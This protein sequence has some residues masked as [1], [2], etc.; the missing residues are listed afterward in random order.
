MFNQTRQYEAS[1]LVKGKSITEYSH[2]DGNVYVEGRPGSEYEL[3]FKN[4]TSLRV[5]VIPSVDGLSVLDGKVAGLNSPGYVINGYGSISIPGWTLDKNQVAK[6][7]FQDTEKSYNA[8]MNKTTVNNGV[9]GFMVFQ[10][11]IPTFV[12]KTIWNGYDLN[13]NYNPF[14]P[15]PPIDWTYRSPGPMYGS[16][17]S[18]GANIGSMSSSTETL[19]ANNLH[20]ISDIGT[21]FGDAVDFQTTEVSFTKRDPN[22]PDALMVV[23]Y[24]SKRGLARRGIN[25]STRYGTPTRNAFPGYSREETV[26]CKTPP[27]YSRQKSYRR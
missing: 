17:L 12:T 7:S 2:T 13:H 20:D 14:N 24:D 16:G 25:V 18:R 9:I 8:V 3:Y 22:N 19:S 23:Y 26:G 1:V 27:G 6:F 10:E 11:N 4:N 5:M 15:E 21:G